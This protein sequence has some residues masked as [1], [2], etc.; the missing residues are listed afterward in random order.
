MIIELILVYE[1][2][3]FDKELAGKFYHC[4]S[5]NSRNSVSLWHKN[6]TNRILYLLHNVNLKGNYHCTINL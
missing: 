6:I 2:F 5:V 3:R 4:C 1:Y